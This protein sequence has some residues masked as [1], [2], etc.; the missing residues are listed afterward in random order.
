MLMKSRLL[1]TV[2]FLAALPSLVLAQDEPIFPKGEKAPNV[3]HTGDVWLNHLSEADSTFDFNV[4]VAT[5]AAGAKLDW[6]MHPAGQQLLI[7]EGT[8][9]YQERDEP[10]QIVRTGD[11]IQCPPG[12]EHWHAATPETGVTYLAI[13]GD[14]PTQWFE[15]VPEEEFNSVNLPASENS[16]SADSGSA[17]AEQ[18]IIDLSK[19]KW[20]WMADKNV[21]VL[22]TLFHDQSEF[23]H[24]GGSWGKERELE[25][26][27]SGGIWYK[28]ADIHETSVQVIG[29]TAILLNRIT[30]LAEV[31][32]DEVTN[33]FEVTEVYVQQGGAWKL[34]S[35]SFTR[36][37]E[38]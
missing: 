13:T 12:I 22:D 33:P 10:V 2:L 30:L 32:G 1:A 8:G 14:E 6:H 38:E 18:E 20:Q 23:V 31:G 25:V 29:E 19:E 11:V 36:L 35:L 21:A 28:E 17:S 9:F 24:M 26:I 7:T 37:L 15:R 34:A 3:H 4:V 27:E 5:F 16:A